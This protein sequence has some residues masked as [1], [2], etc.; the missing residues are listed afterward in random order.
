MLRQALATLSFCAIAAGCWL[1]HPAAGLIVP[2]LI[3]F[4][5]L[6]WTHFKEEGE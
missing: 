1:L 5:S 3:V 6:A 2:G 4:G